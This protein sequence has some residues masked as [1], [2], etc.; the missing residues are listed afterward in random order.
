MTEQALINA[1]KALSRRLAGV[2]RDQDRERLESELAR[3]EE[4]LDASATRQRREVRRYH[5]TEVR[6]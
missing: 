5:E 2:L 6:V 3:L 1:V 4:A